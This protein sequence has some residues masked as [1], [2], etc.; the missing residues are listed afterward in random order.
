[1]S[2]AGLLINTVTVYRPTVSYTKGAATKT[3]VSV[4][5]GVK[6]NIQFSTGVAG[7]GQG[8]IQVTTHGQETAEDYWAAFE[9]GADV[10]KG[11]KIVDED[12]R[13]FIIVTAPIDV[14]GREHHIEA[15]LALDEQ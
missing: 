1:M 12:G 13:S 5:T 8:S 11:D 14:V 3:F 7:Y 9:H 15:K 4:A 2:F 6:C 10:Q